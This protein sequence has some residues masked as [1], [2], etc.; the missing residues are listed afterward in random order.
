MNRISNFRVI[1]VTDLKITW[2]RKTSLKS[3]LSIAVQYSLLLL[4]TCVESS[5]QTLQTFMTRSSWDLAPR[6]FNYI[7]F[8]RQ[9]KVIIL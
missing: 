4:F 3:C 6:P 2:L 1:V 9:E 7:T 8:V 5:V